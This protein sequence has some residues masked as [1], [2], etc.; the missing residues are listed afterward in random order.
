M[1]LSKAIVYYT[2]NTHRMD[3]E[4]A[5][6]RQLEK[7]KLPII[8]VSRE[9][10]IDFGDIKAVV[11]GERSPLT[12]HRQVFTGLQLAKFD[13]VFLCES[14]VLYHPSHFDLDPENMQTFYYNTNVW[15]VRYP[16]GHAIWTDDLQQVSGCFASRDLLLEFYTKRLEQIQNEGFNRHY[17]PGVKQT[18]G[19]KFVKNSQSSFPNLDIRHDK[20]ITLSKWSINDFRNKDYAKGWKEDSWVAGWGTTEGRFEEFLKE[21]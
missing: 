1:S 21:I 7:T 17:E 4:L 20:N 2:C 8:S 14:D 12:M 18:V 10:E 3:I 9:K 11:F 19:S 5:C 6:R 16:D 15:R 13:I